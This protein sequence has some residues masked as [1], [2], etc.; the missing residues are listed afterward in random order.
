MQHLERGS[1]KISLL[2][3]VKP[4]QTMPFKRQTIGTQ[5]IVS[6]HPI[7]IRQELPEMLAANRTFHLIA[8]IERPDQKAKQIAQL[9]EP[10]AG[11]NLGEKRDEFLHER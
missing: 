11:K 9:D 4:Q 6:S 10:L 7:A 1:E 8:Q 3:Q 5:S 2:F